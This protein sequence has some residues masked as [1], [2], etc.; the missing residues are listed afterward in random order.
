MKPKGTRVGKGPTSD[1]KALAW[2]NSYSKVSRWLAQWDVP[3]LLEANDGFF[4]IPN[5]LPPAVAE[6]ALRIVERIPESN[7]LPTAADQD[8]SSHNNI[9]HS[10]LSTKQGPNLEELLRVFMLLLPEH[11]NVFSAAKYQRSDRIAPHDDK[12][13]TP[14]RMADTGE[15]VLCSRDI[16]MV[17]YLAKDWKPEMG[18]AFIDLVTG[19]KHVPEFNTAVI[20]K[21]PRFHEVEAVAV[22]RPRYSIFGWYLLPGQLYDLFDGKGEKEG[23]KEE[24]GGVAGNGKLVKKDK[25][26]HK[27]RAREELRIEEEEDGIELDENGVPMC[28]LARR[29]LAQGKKKKRKT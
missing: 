6:E 11:L 17:Y 22:D 7:W 25:T 1:P 19:I 5:F 28:K 3:Q 9:E 10:F 14:I 15:V 20:F 27:E 2:L 29:I 18:G 24:N 16:T 21:V 13:F 12:A 8:Y 26:R 4:K 23:G